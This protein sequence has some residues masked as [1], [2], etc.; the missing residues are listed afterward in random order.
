[1][2]TVPDEL[3]KLEPE[4]EQNLKLYLKAVFALQEFDFN[5]YFYIINKQDTML[6]KVIELD[7]DGY[8]LQP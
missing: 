6:Q 5:S 2:K 7:R 8:P 1:M 3:E 4:Q